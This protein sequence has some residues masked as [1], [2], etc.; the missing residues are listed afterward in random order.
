MI[1]PNSLSDRM[2]VWFT[3]QMLA[4]DDVIL[5]ELECIAAQYDALGGDLK[6]GTFDALMAE[7]DKLQAELWRRHVEKILNQS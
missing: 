2:K 6:M 3:P 7:S 5:K 4:P 1:D